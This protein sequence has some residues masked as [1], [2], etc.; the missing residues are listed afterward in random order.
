MENKG[1]T[2]EKTEL[3]VKELVDMDYEGRVLRERLVVDVRSEVIPN[4]ISP[5]MLQAAPRTVAVIWPH[6]NHLDVL[7]GHV[8]LPNLCSI[9]KDKYEFPTRKADK[10]ADYITARAR[11]SDSA[12][13]VDG[14]CSLACTWKDA[15]LWLR[16]VR[17]CDAE[18]SLSELQEANAREAIRSFGLDMIKDCLQRTFERDPHS[19]RSLRFLNAIDR[20]RSRYAYTIPFDKTYW[21][22]EQRA[23]IL[24]SLRLQDVDCEGAKIVVT[25]AIEARAIT[26]LVNTLLPYIKNLG[27]SALLLEF[28]A[29]VHEK[30]AF[31]TPDKTRMIRDSLI[32]AISRAHFVDS[33][34][35]PDRLVKLAESLVKTCVR[36]GQEDFIVTIVAYLTNVTQDAADAAA[37]WRGATKILLPFV[38]IVGGLKLSSDVAK[39]ALK[40]LCSSTVRMYLDHASAHPKDVSR[41]D[42][43]PLFHAVAFTDEAEEVL[44]HT[45][46]RLMAMELEAEIVPAILDAVNTHGPRSAGGDQ[47]VMSATLSIA[48]KYVMS[49]EV[50]SSMSPGLRGEDILL[51]LE[52][53]IGINTPQACAMLLERVLSVEMKAEVRAFV[54]RLVPH[55]RELLVKHDRTRASA[56]TALYRAI[57]VY[58]VDKQMGPRPQFDALTALIQKAKSHSCKWQSCQDVH[59]FLASVTLD[60]SHELSANSV[61]VPTRMHIEDALKEYTNLG[62]SFWRVD[63]HHSQLHGLSINK[64]NVLL[65]PLAWLLDQR[66]GS[67]LLKDTG[68]STTEL[69]MILGAD[70]ARVVSALAVPVVP[71]SGNTLPIAPRALRP[72]PASRPDVGPPAS[73]TAPGAVVVTPQTSSSISAHASVGN[74]VKRA[75]EDVWQGAS[76]PV[77]RKDKRKRN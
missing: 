48:M 12:I 69:Q 28:A 24:S 35:D 26:F 11:P 1:T 50:S 14:V 46:S 53:C 6:C 27:D 8:T 72:R 51:A 25:A 45:A 68:A 77:G 55:L 73:G 23:K 38:S 44:F 67:Q 31:P 30:P 37:T 13:I 54:I 64:G 49:V 3:I 59:A 16:A 29:Q 21:I 76:A 47:K 61:D 22:N 7:H 75:N 15:G 66:N 32:C 70:Y 65:E 9:L 60:A 63:D 5:G 57:F 52:R 71:S 39:F 4:D 43:G 74:G 36:V 40:M 56:Y 42:I 19:L 62:V 18:R 58:W 10:F 20:E 33:A 17:A 41:E 2:E 34:T